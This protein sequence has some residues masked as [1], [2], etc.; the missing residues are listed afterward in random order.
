VSDLEEWKG[1]TTFTGHKR[2]TFNNKDKLG[3]EN[4]I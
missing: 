3:I 1:T 2:E 4:T